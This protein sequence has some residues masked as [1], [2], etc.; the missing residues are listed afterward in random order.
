VWQRFEDPSRWLPV[1]WSTDGPEAGVLGVSLRAADATRDGHDDVLAFSATGGSGGCGIVRVL[2][3][4]GSAGVGPAVGVV[5]ERSVC[6]A[7][8]SVV[9]RGLELQE[10]LYRPGDAH[11][12]PSATRTSVLAYRGEGRWVVVS[13][14]TDPVG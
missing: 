3:P 6:D 13:K 14:R 7:T 11:C 4:D 8:V 1:A 5:F 9:P 2:A 10:A 12:C